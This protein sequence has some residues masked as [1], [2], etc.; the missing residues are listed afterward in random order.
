MSSPNGIL[1][2]SKSNCGGGVRGRKPKEIPAPMEWNLI[3]VSVH[4]T[5]KKKSKQYKNRPAMLRRA[6]GGPM[7][8]CRRELTSQLS[9]VQLVYT[10]LRPLSCGKAVCQI[11]LPPSLSGRGNHSEIFLWIFPQSQLQT[12]SF[13]SCDILHYYSGN[14]HI[15]IPIEMMSSNVFSSILSHFIL[16]TYLLDCARPQLQHGGPSTFIAP[17]GIFS[18]STWDPVPRP[19]IEPRPPALGAQS[20]YHWTTKK[21]AC[22][23]LFKF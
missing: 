11:H 21:V 5:Q 8:P 19:G 4:N 14:I 13:R 2:K 22:S 6:E 16:L 20:L 18:F 23:I 10:A 12:F 7:Q 17:H 9:G 3:K 15:P 1:S